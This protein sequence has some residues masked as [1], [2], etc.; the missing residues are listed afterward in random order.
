MLTRES[1][2]HQTRSDA[3]P[4]HQ[5]CR[6]STTCGRPLSISGATIDYSTAMPLPMEM[7]SLNDVTG[8]AEKGIFD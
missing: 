8:K 6:C 4:A 3:T 7:L 1:A 2:L 5:G